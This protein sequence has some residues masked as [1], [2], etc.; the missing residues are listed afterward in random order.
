M[1]ELWFEQREAL[2]NEVEAHRQGEE[3]AADSETAR[4]GLW[5]ARAEELSRELAIKASEAHAHQKRA[6]ALQ[7]QLQRAADEAAAKD[8]GAAPQVTARQ[9][10]ADA[11][12]VDVEAKTKS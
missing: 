12:T 10:G 3:L 7:M 6:Q 2:L 4:K 8:A 11:R 9:A 1:E 5:K